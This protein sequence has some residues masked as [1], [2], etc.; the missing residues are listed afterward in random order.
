MSGVQ[1]ALAGA[2]PLLYPGLQSGFEQVS[3]DEYIEFTVYKKFVVPLD[4]SVFWIR[5]GSFRAQGSLHYSTGRQQREDETQGLDRVVFTTGQRVADFNKIAPDILFVGDVN[6]FRFSFSS[7][8]PLYQNAGLFHYVGDSVWP[9]MESQLLD[10]ITEVPTLVVSN[11]LPIWLTLQSYNPIWLEPPNPNITLYPSYL[12]PD[13]TRP[14]YGTVHIEPRGTQAVE[15]VPLL[16]SMT[17]HQQLAC[18]YVRVTLYGATNGQAASWLDLALRYIRDNDYTA[19]IGL[20]NTPI[21]RDDKRGQVEIAAIA[22]KKTIDLEVSY[23]QVAVNNIAQ[24][25]FQQAV[26]TFVP[27]QWN[28]VDFKPLTQGS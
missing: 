12:V 23:L 25:A 3:S 18:D 27:I 17:N 26:E 13:N 1:E 16:D 14:P 22:M 28:S 5:S 24:Q 21:I 20:M 7:H 11:S 9:A 19:G 15:A 6:G 10:N 4:G 8:G 2:S